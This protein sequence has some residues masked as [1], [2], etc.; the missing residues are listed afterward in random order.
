MSNDNR[1]DGTTKKAKAERQVI[2]QLAPFS[3]ISIPTEPRFL[4]RNLLPS[5]GLGLVWGPPKTGKTF[6]VTDLALHVALGLDYRGLRTKKG[7]VIYIACEGETGL[8]ARLAAFRKVK[9]NGGE[10]DFH[11]LASGLSLIKQTATLITDIKQ[12]QVRP[13]LIIIDT[14]NRSLEGSESSDEDMAKYIKAAD[15]LSFAFECLVLIVHHCGHD[16]NRPR[17]HSSLLGAL[18]VQIAVRRETNGHIISTVE[19]MKDGEEGMRIVSELEVVDLGDDTDGEV[20]RSCVVKAVKDHGPHAPN[21]EVLQKGTAIALK[22]LKAVALPLKDVATDTGSLP[23]EATH[24]VLETDWREKFYEM[25]VSSSAKARARQQAFLRAKNTLQSKSLI[26][27]NGP[28][29]YL[30]NTG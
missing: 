13:A 28:Y 23:A 17:G 11:L 7:P 2:F 30:L 19:R 10:P 9:L 16:K 15:R 1:S 6:W 12:Q 25:A 8:K 24:A 14:L 5:E 20:I 18:D 21:K 22:A 27:I 4:V 29:V 26:E 3:S